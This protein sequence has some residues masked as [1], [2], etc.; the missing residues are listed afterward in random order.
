MG[1]MLPTLA[2]N[3]HVLLNCH[4]HSGFLSCSIGC[5]TVLATCCSCYCSCLAWSSPASARRKRMGRRAWSALS[6]LI[7]RV[8]Q[9]AMG[10]PMATCMKTVA[11]SLMRAAV[12]S[13]NKRIGWGRALPSRQTSAMPCG[14]ANGA[15]FP[16]VVSTAW[17]GLHGQ[18]LLDDWGHPS[19]GQD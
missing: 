12:T 7:I 2:V 17:S 10:I 19:D 4:F 13:T 5:A 14:W 11:N 18:S 1:I 15:V 3:Q 9:T 6:R 8:I 16:C